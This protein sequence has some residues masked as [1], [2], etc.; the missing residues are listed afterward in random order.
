[1]YFSGIEKRPWDKVEWALT[2]FQG[3]RTPTVEKDVFIK[4]YHIAPQDLWITNYPRR[5]PVAAFNPGAL[6]RDGKLL[7]F[8]RLV[9]DYYT[10]NSSVGVFELDIEVVRQAWR[11]PDV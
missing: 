2:E 6:K 11:E 4:R 10:Y 9:F 1:M 7:V 8:P 3:V 5:Q